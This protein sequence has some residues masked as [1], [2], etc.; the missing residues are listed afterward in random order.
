ML[1]LRRCGSVPLR[2]GS[3]RGAS[4]SSARAWR[5]EQRGPYSRLGDADLAMFERLLGPSAVLTDPEDTGPFNRDWLNTCQGSAGAVLLPASTAE[6]SAVLSHCHARG[7]AVC[8]QGGNT[9]LV[10]G[11]VPVFDEL[12]LS[13]S[14]MARVLAIDPLTGSVSCEAGCVLATLDE[15]VAAEASLAVPLDLGA[16]GSCQL[17]GNVATN[18][19]GLRLLRYGPLHGSLLGL[20]AVLA[21]GTVLDVM[22]TLRKDNT[23]LDLKQLFIGSEGV[24]GVITRLAI[25]CVPRPRAVCVAFL[26]CPRF[27]A[28]LETLQVARRLLLEFLSAVEVMDAE[29]LC[30]VR[31]NLHLRMPLAQEHP[32]CLLIELSGSDEGVLE[33]SLLRFVDVCMSE[34]HVSDGTVAQDSARIQELWRLRESVGE[35][36][37][38]DGCVY[39]YDVSLPL[40]SFMA[41]VALLRERLPPQAVRR[42]CGFGHL[43]DSN[44]HLNVTSGHWDEALLAALEPFVYEWTAAH[45]GSISAEHGIGRLKRRYLHLAR[46][47]AAIEAMRRLKHT[48]DPRGILNPY[49][50]LP[51]E[52]H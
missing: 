15:R 31:D 35:A 43:G 12:V 44:L 36:L 24:L 50:M 1:L 51:E 22:Q 11:S 30:C 4:S 17:G 47:P 29:T 28:C 2:P 37:R 41:P 46:P 20:E 32:F 7:L 48:F 45:G 27:E 16:K 21:D 34:S 38:R 18:A 23:G 14:R 3:R 26:G 39:K 25:Q 5:G 42:V 9:G 8:P 10:G 6:V 33:E 40:G 13:T 19:G 52:Q 49:K